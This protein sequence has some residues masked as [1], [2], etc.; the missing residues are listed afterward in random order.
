MK[1]TFM[2]IDEAMDSADPNN[3]KVD[4]SSTSKDAISKL[5]HGENIMCYDMKRC[6]YTVRKI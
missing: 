4:I 2:I 5:N 3:N 1:S 6:V